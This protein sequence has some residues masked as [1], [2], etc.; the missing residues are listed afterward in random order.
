MFQCNSYVMRENII[1]FSSKMTKKA[2]DRLVM[3]RIII[4]NQIQAQARKSLESTVESS[5]MSMCATLNLDSVPQAIGSL[6]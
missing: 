5:M 6:S 1:E 4:V 2:A 3:M